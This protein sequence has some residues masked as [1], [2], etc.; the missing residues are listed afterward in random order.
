M[1]FLL[2]ATFDA[3]TSSPNIPL[4]QLVDGLSV[5]VLIGGILSLLLSLI[6]SLLCLIGRTESNRK[7]AR[8]SFRRPDHT[9]LFF[10]RIAQYDRDEYVEAMN[11]TSMEEFGSDLAS[12]IHVLS[13]LAIEKYRWLN[14]ALIWLIVSI[15][16][17]LLLGMTVFF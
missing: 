4:I 8:G 13:Q 11:S 10:G 17:F 2:T 9:L 3:T 6:S 1:G 12:Q 7:I 15:F 14:R 16:L 5:F